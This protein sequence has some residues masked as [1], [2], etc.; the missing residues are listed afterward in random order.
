MT[1]AFLSVMLLMTLVRCG[2]DPLAFAI[3]PI[4]VGYDRAEVLDADAIDI[5]NDGDSDLVAATAADLRYLEFSEGRYSE[6][7]A[8]T[9]LAKVSAVE[10]MHR[11]GN[12]Y[13]VK[14]G[15]E[16]S[17]LEYSGI[18][19][20]RESE[21]AVENFNPEPM[22]EA[23]ADFDLDGQ[24]DRAQIINNT[25]L[26][27][28]AHGDTWIDVTSRVAVDGL[29]LPKPGRRIRAADLEGDGDMDLIVVGGRLF[30]LINNG[31]KFAQR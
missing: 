24:I 4:P 3:E 16:L 23:R 18:G 19:T 9:G 17:R 1:K 6:M 11:D 25:L 27:E 28:L 2:K 22:L 15:N 5:D 21:D 20:W 14:R 26:V 29:M 13:I 31:G 10:T 7:T 30:R 12:D 8:G